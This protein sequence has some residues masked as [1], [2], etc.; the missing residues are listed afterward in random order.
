[1]DGTATPKGRVLR[2][3]GTG[4]LPGPLQALFGVSQCGRVSFDVVVAG[5][6]VAFYWDGNALDGGWTVEGLA[7]RSGLWGGS[8]RVVKNTQRLPRG[9]RG[10]ADVGPGGLEAG[11]EDGCEVEV[12]MGVDGRPPAQ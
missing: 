9:V 1:M 2:F 10:G 12:I 8:V 5:W 11:S 6:N 3:S 7:P 4:A